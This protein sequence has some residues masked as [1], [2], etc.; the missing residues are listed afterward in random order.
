MPQVRA[1]VR[2]PDLGPD[3]AEGAVLEQD[4]GVALF[5]LIEARPATVRLEL[6][7]RAE[8][9]GAAGPAVVDAASLGVRVLAGEGRLRACLPQD[10]VFLRRQP[11]APFVLGELHIC[12]ANE[13]TG[14]YVATLPWRG[15]WPRLRPGQV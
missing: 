5:R 14:Q 15:G 10:V 7:V 3:P 1:A 6:G 2:T 12:H 4:D 11:L 9:L 13:T 8:Q